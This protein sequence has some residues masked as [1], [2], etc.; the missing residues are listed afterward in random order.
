[1]LMRIPSIFFFACSSFLPVTMSFS[2]EP[3]PQYRRITLLKVLQIYY[4]K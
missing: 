1:M 3:L 2:N 4:K